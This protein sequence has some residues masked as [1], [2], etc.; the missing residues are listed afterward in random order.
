MDPRDPIYASHPSQSI[1]DAAY[2]EDSPYRPGQPGGSMT[3][4]PVSSHQIYTPSQSTDPYSGISPFTATSHQIPPASSSAP[5]HVD[6]PRAQVIPSS[7]P[8]PYDPTRVPAAYFPPIS[9]GNIHNLN[10]HPNHGHNHNNH[11]NSNNSSSI[12][13]AHI[14]DSHMQPTPTPPPGSTRYSPS[15]RPSQSPYPPSSPNP[16]SAGSTLENDPHKLGPVAAARLRKKR[17]LQLC[18][19]ALCAFALF[20]VAL[21]VGVA[22]GVLKVRVSDSGDGHH[23]GGTPGITEN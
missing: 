10:P 20:F 11:S 7:P 2:P 21:I 17:K 13:L 19:I 9:D 3:I 18:C 8:P 16:Y 5:W 12:S 6:D 15:P 1:P 22:L 4:T 14:P 23:G